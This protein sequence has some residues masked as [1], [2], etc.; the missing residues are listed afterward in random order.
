M[1][2]SSATIHIDALRENLRRVRELAP[3]RKVMAIVK[4]DGYGH[5]L[6]RVARALQGADGFGVACIADGQRLRAAGVSQRIV[7]LSGLDEPADLSEMRRL[8]L[9]SVVHHPVQIDWLAADRDAR[10]LRVWLKI[11]TGMHRLGFAPPQVRDAYARLR[12]LPSVHRDIGLMTHFANSDAFDD[13]LTTRQVD[14]F[15]AAT[16][17]LAGERA[18]ANSAGVLGWPEAHGDWVRAGGALYGISVVEGRVG[19]DFGFR[20]AMT[21][22]SRLIAINRLVR[23]DRIGYASTWQCPEDM[24][25]GVVAIGYGDG[26]PR[27]AASGTPVLLDGRYAPIVGRVSMDLVTIDLRAHPQARIGDPVILWGRGLPV[28]D[29]AAHAGTIGYDLTCGVTRRVR[30]TEE[31]G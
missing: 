21:L 18:L 22:S 4:A 3:G 25:V 10:P 15:E 9:E 23:G 7:V 16:V 1:R 31:A 8:N 12:E 11:D 13:P 6:E 29:V 28:E 27:S 5:G 2:A 30:F 19:A 20:P 17:G 26:Y 14:A 24:A